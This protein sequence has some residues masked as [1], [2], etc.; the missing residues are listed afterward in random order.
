M[1]QYLIVASSSADESKDALFTVLKSR[2]DKTK[3]ADSVHLL[4]IPENLKFGSFDSLIKYADDLGKQD[5]LVDATLRRVERHLC[6]LEPKSDFKVYSNRS[7]V[8]AEDYLLHFKWDDAKF[9]RSRPIQDNL[10]V[11]SNSVSRLDDEVKSRTQALLDLRQQVASIS[12]KEAASLVQRDLIDVLTP[13]TITP[14]DFVYTEHLTTLVVVVPRGA[15][16][17]WLSSYEALDPYV[18]PQ[19]STQLPADDKDGNKLYRVILFRSSSDNFKQA[20][21]QHRF[22]VRDFH[23]DPEK[24]HQTAT[25]RAEMIAEV[26][27]QET[28]VKK[29]CQAAF[30]DCLVALVHLKA[31]RVYVEAV[32]RFGLPPKFATFLIKP[33]N[34]RI[35]RLHA[36][37]ADVLGN[38]VLG[39]GYLGAADDEEGGEFHPYVN[40]AVVV[41]RN[42]A[43]IAGR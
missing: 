33:G 14:D 21:R 5:A 17:E 4:D 16:K 18:V 37:L 31:V 7:E 29:I 26:K 41:N 19:S 30:S 6:E 10:Q 2:L 15:E 3:L 8:L 22:L 24:Y 13:E 42:P 12:K 40:F 43:G 25:V 28:L 39:K 9:P 1:S 27:R 36:E 23:F 32:L 38:G 20:A 34:G 35:S 11:L